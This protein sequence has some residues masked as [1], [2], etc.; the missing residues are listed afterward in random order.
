ML[1]A[2]MPKMNV[3]K[4][5]IL[6]QALPAVGIR[7]GMTRPCPGPRP[8][9]VTLTSRRGEWP[10]PVRV[11]RRLPVAGAATRRVAKWAAARVLA[12]STSGPR[13]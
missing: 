3:W 11:I 2:S 8:H 6:A 13:A 10:R 1:H 12:G 5:R 4:G 7:L 9:P